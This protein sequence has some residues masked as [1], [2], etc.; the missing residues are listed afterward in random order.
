MIYFETSTVALPFFAGM[1]PY[2]PIAFQFSHHIMYENGKIEHT[3]QALFV[4]P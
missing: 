1:R 2:E 3:S 4:E